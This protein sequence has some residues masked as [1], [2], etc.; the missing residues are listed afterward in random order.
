MTLFKIKKDAQIAVE[1][2]TPVPN[3][4]LTLFDN[5]KCCPYFVVIWVIR[6]R[7]SVFYGTASLILANYFFK[8]YFFANHQ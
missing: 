1:E 3:L 2:G 6:K 5:L 7:K 4:I 8:S